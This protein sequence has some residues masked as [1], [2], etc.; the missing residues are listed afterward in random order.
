MEVDFNAFEAGDGP[1]G[2]SFNATTIAAKDPGAVT[3]IYMN[4]TEDYQAVLADG[5]TEREA[6]VRA[7][8]QTGDNRSRAARI[9]RVS[10]RTFY[11]KLEIHGLL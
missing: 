4:V 1:L 5:A 8:Q 7:L 11:N 6:I 9:I 3:G 2:G 10:R